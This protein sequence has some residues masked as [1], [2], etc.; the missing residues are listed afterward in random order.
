V[1]ICKT[2]I[3]LPLTQNLK[4]F[5]PVSG[6][7]DQI[8]CFS[9][10]KLRENLK[11]RFVIINN[12]NIQRFSHNLLN[13]LTRLASQVLNRKSERIPRSL[14]RGERANLKMA[15]FLTVAA[16]HCRRAEHSLQL[17][18]G[19]FNLVMIAEKIASHFN[20]GPLS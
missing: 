3:N 6:S 7:Q 9:L 1:Q 10:K 8:V 15:H 14:L 5:R 2:E 19:S 17:T 16:K 18:A 4:R 20:P 13:A 12:Q 11:D